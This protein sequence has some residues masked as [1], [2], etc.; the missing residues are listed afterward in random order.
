[1]GMPQDRDAR[2]ADLVRRLPSAPPAVVARM[3][4]HLKE[5]DFPVRGLVA[6]MEDFYAALAAAGSPPE[7]VTTGIF[8]GVATSRSRLRALLRGL[9][10]FDPSVPLEPAAPVTQAWDRWLNT[11]YNQ[12][13]RKPRLSTRLAARPEDWPDS[14]Q[15]ILPTLD[16][17]VRPHGVALRPP[18]PRTRD[19]IIQAVGMLATS[20]VWARDRDVDLPEPPG[21]DLIEAFHCYLVN[22]R[23]VSPVTVVSY[24]E[25]I[26]M[27]FLRGG[28]LDPETDAEM[29]E[30]IGLNTEL[31]GEQDP[32]KRRIVKAFRRQFSIA[33]LLHKAVAAADEVRALP[34]H[35]TEALRLR[36]KSVAY[37]LLLN[38]A[39]R[40]GDLRHLRIGV[41]LLRDADGVWHH[42]LRQSKT[43]VRKP[44]GP[45]WPVTCALIDAHLLAD[46]PA[47]QI[48]ARYAELQCCNLL[49]LRETVLGKTFINRRLAMDVSLTL[50]DGKISGHLV[51]T[52]VTDAIRRARPDAAWAA[53]QMLGHSDRWM[54][55]TYRSDFVE[56]GAVQGM[57]HLIEQIATRSEAGSKAIGQC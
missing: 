39:D 25:R 47:W 54:Q 20:R 30:L 4:A 31:A 7:E 32:A 43:G 2:A 55:E 44:L 51:R 1:M 48:E 56:A 14:W 3:Q 53:Q 57:G 18:A 33:I 24:L 9:A 6:V 37:A 49:T 12:K 42:D 41:D 10:A 21:A 45:L 34:G 27:L 40:Q 28:L 5:R 8:E 50:P 15:Q 46:R 19:A 22:E 11:R 17:T 35:R 26:R 16:R 36:Q 38:T 29:S 52:L 23:G 13:P